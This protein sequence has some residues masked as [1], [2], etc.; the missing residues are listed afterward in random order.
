MNG[1]CRLNM[2]S[3]YKSD[4]NY[5]IVDEDDNPFQKIEENDLMTELVDDLSEKDYGNFSVR[6]NEFFAEFQKWLED[7]R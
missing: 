2:K 3:C 6:W 5:Y 7:D 1:T 4:G